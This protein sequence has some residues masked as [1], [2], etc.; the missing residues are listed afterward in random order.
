MH[1]IAMQLTGTFPQSQSMIISRF[2]R[3]RRETV[4]VPWD[5]V[6]SINSQ[7][8]TIDHSLEEIWKSRYEPGGMLLGRNLLDRQIVDLHGNKVV[9]ANDLRLAEFDSRLR[10]VGVDVSQRALLRRLGLEKTA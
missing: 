5:W 2:R 4:G 9:R 3:G 6:S 10:L 7:E 8:V 1:D